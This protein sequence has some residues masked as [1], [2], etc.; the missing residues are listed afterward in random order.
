MGVPE[1]DADRGVSAAGLQA[2]QQALAAG[3]LQ[4]VRYFAQID[5][6]NTA[7]CHDLTR[8][9]ADQPQDLPRMYL[10]DRQTAGRG[11][12]GRQWLA[13]TGTLTFSV[14]YGVDAVHPQAIKPQ[15][16]SLV[17]LATGVAISRAVEYLAAPVAAR[18]KWP[19]D[20]YVAGGKVA[21]VLV[22]S[23]ASHSGA[24]VVGVGVNVATD[25]QQFRD[26]IP[27]NANSL[28]Q[29]ACGPTERYQWLPEML[30]QMRQAYEQLGNEPERLLEELRCRC[31]LSGSEVRFQANGRAEQGRCVGIAADGALLVQCGAELRP[32]RSGEV[33][34]VRR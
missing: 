9:A 31:L 19:N 30:S 28:R 3:D 26:A 2:C 6:T 1:I 22:E 14:I 21:G 15:A 7:A 13:D 8:G 29:V 20:V 32:L 4:A 16:T 27:A 10:A 18:I 11:R 23:V 12:M 5:S 24:L 33:W 34:Q 25:L 17:A